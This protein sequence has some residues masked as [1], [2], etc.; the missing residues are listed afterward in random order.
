MQSLTIIQ[1]DDA[2]V[3]LRDGNYL[4]RTVPDVAGRFARAV[5]MP[6][7]KPPITTL[8]QVNEYK[9]RIMAAVPAGV[10]FEPLMTLYLTDDMSPELLQQASEQHAITAVKLYPAG[11]T[12]NSQAGVT[13]F[14]QL[15]PVFEAMQ[16]YAIPL[17]IHGEINDAS[18][19]IFDREKVF[20]ETLAELTKQFPALRIVLEHITTR[21]AVQFVTTASPNI[22]ATITVHHL[23]LNRNDMLAGGVRPHYYCLPILKRQE[24]QKALLAAATSGNKKFFLGT[25]SA[26]HA[27]PTKE[28]ACG[29]AGIYSAHAAIELYAQVF[30]SMGCLDKLEAFAS[31]YAA[32]FYQLSRNTSTITL[33]KK[34]WRVPDVLAFGDETLVPLFAGTNVEWK[35]SI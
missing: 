31:H 23:L 2:H 22:A 10:N 35:K 32:D 29:C 9:Q 5:V 26:P 15:Y 16:R 12:T 21:E 14:R 27:K 1:P 33:Q 19:D 11:A 17:L 28:N 34:S 3:H 4:Q 6:N 8:A 20:L 18:V 24:D 30:D 13:N 25:D 7:L